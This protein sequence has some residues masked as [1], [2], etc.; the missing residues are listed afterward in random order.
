[1]TGTAAGASLPLMD[2]AARLALLDDLHR[3]HD[4]APPRQAVRAALLGGDPAWRASRDRAALAEQAR[5]AAEARHAAAR[6]R[7]VLPASRCF[8][9]SWLARLAATLAHHRTAAMRL[10]EAQRK[11]YSQ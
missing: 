6:R 11:A 5:L 1:M 8:Q 2:P 9:D 4:G 10:L 7:A 3:R